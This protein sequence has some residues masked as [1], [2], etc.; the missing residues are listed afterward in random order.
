M[1]GNIP[2]TIKHCYDVAESGVHAAVADEHLH[3]ARWLE[4]YMK[5]I[6]PPDSM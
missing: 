2:E 5:S 3:L 1:S 4:D 6:N